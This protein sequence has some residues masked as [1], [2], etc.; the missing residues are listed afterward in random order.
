MRRYP[1]DDD[2]DECLEKD[3]ADKQ[4][5]HAGKDGKGKIFSKLVYE[6][7]CNKRDDHRDKRCK[8]RENCYINEDLPASFSELENWPFEKS[9]FLRHY[10]FYVISHCLTIVEWISRGHLLHR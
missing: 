10:L 6:H 7:L 4:Q 2:G 3:G 1:N 8:T 9:E 5:R